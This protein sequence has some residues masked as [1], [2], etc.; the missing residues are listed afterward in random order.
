MV[1][2]EKK[3]FKLWTV[4]RMG[5]KLYLSPKEF[6]LVCDL[7][8]RYYKHSYYKPCT[9]SPKTINK[10]IKDLNIIWDNGNKKD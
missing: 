2:F 9:C 3:D 4:F 8:S 10:W 6:E 1:K 5:K 7:H